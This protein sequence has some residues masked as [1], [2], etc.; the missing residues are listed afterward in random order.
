MAIVTILELRD[1]GAHF[2]DVSEEASV[3]GLLLQG[4]VE[5]LGNAILSSQQ[6]LF[7]RTVKRP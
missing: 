2:F 3:N 7:V 1:G 4:A 5:A 6:L